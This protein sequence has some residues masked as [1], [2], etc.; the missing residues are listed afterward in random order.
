[1]VVLVLSIAGDQLPVILF[2]DFV[3]NAASG[4]PEQI[5]GTCSKEGIVFESIFIG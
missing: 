5:G 1:V 4:V 3:G 2:L